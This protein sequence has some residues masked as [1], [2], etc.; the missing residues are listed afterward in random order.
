[1][2]TRSHIEDGE[3]E[4]FGDVSPSPVARRAGQTSN[5]IPFPTP[6]PPPWLGDG[7]ADDC[8][9]QVGLVAVRML[10]RW[11]LPRIVVRMSAPE[12]QLEEGNDPPGL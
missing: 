6:L 2:T 8:F 10:A 11:S 7:E 5:V 9:E 1:M 12:D 4:A 3:S